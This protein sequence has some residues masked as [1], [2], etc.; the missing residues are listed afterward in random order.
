M[1]NINNKR[2]IET[3]P[4]LYQAM[5]AY[6]DFTTEDISQF[7]AN[8]RHTKILCLARGE[9]AV[10]SPVVTAVNRQPVKW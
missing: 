1:I 3:I 2:F 7:L 9:R 5:H 6:L 8:I 4:P 10:G